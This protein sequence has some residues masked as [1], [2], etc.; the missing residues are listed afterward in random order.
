D[1]RNSLRFE[2]SAGDCGTGG[3][4][5]L[6]VQA[7]SSAANLW[8]N[9]GVYGFDRLARVASAQAH[10]YPV[11]TGQNICRSQ[12]WLCSCCTVGGPATCGTSC[13]GTA[14]LGFND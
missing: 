9:G 10:A 1:A 3:V 14:V 11:D 8:E 6:S 5:C 12:G 4:A 7:R 13:D 2:K